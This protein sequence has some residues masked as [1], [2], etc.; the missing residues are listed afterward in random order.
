M[1]IM[2]TYLFASDSCYWGDMSLPKKKSPKKWSS[3]LTMVQL[4]LVKLS[5]GRV[6]VWSS[7]RLVKL[8]LID[9]SVVELSVVELSDYR[10]G[11]MQQ[12]QWGAEN[13]RKVSRQTHQSVLTCLSR[14][15]AAAAAAAGNGNRCLLYTSPIGWLLLM[16]D[17]SEVRT[18]VDR[19]MEDLG[20][21][22]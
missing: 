8:V 9:L 21:T 16:Y 10:I 22:E 17:V 20:L 3:W 2:P 12:Q 1:N 4:V 19:L 15:I 6:V 7:C 18:N 5:F 14:M 13:E 11:H